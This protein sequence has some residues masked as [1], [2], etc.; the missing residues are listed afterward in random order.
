MSSAGLHPDTVHLKERVPAERWKR[1][2]ERAHERAEILEFAAKRYAGKA[3]SRRSA[4]RA[5]AP[6]VDWST[7]WH[8]CRCAK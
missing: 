1:I 4:L 5:V 7:S 3:E 6:D 8:W 2:E